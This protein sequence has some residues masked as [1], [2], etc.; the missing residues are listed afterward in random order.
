MTEHAFSHST[1]SDSARRQTLQVLVDALTLDAKHLVEELRLAGNSMPCRAYQ[2]A[3]AV[4]H[5]L[6]LILPG[7]RY[8]ITQHAFDDAGAVIVIH[9]NFDDF[10]NWV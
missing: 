7:M 1:P 3:K 4:P 5:R 9:V 8:S 6:M 10:R 2:F